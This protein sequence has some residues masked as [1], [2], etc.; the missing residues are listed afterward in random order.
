MKAKPIHPI[1]SGF[2]LVEMAIVLVIIGLLLGGL[3]MP[4][5]AQVEQRR[6]SET[7]KTL[8]EIRESLIGFAISNGRLPCP[9]TATIAS[10]MA[11]AGL[12]ACNGGTYGNCTQCANPSGA[13][14]WATLGISETDAWGWRFSYRITGYFSQG[15]AHPLG[16]GCT[17]DT[18]P[19]K[20]SF[21]LCSPGDNTIC[22]SNTNCPGTN[23]ASG[24]PAIVVSHGKNGAGAHNTQ[25]TQ[26]PVSTNADEAANSDGNTSFVSHTP[27]APFDDIVTWL[28]PNTLFNRMV[29]AQKLP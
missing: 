27:T 12:E 5:S 18:T 21:A 9:A 10:G 17:P 8:D 1:A 29:S 4:L 3:L 20:A 6:I 22:P 2:T 16:L 13:L 25:G 23:I 15:I 28:S 14:P 19:T 24:I 26:I 11:N 7:Q